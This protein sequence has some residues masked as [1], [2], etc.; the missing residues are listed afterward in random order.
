M[1][2]YM[3]YL[4]E[5]QNIAW[6][7]LAIFEKMIN[8]SKESIKLKIKDLEVTMLCKFCLAI[9]H[10]FDVLLGARRTLIEDIHAFIKDYAVE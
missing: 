4:K 1:T 10:N 3:F 5:F 2:F 9:K 6:E 8:S 7:R